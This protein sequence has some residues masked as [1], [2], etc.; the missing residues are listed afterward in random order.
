[1]DLGTICDRIAS[2]GKLLKDHGYVDSDGGGTKPWSIRHSNG[3]LH[4]DTRMSEWTAYD[5]DCEVCTGADPESLAQYLTE[6]Y[7]NGT[8]L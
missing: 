4:I 5:G 6:D 1:M 3:N 8:G 2:Y 7:K